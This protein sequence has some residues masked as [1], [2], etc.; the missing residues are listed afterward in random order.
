VRGPDGKAADERI[1]SDVRALWPEGGYTLER[2]KK[3]R[4]RGEHGWW[5]LYQQSPN[6]RG[7]GMFKRADFKIVDDR[8]LAGAG[9]G[10]GTSRRRPSGIARSPPARSSGSSTAR[11]S[12]PT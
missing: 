4:M 5:S 2:L 9:C 7:G 11:S 10:A 12:S 1:D 3:T 6:P 8:P